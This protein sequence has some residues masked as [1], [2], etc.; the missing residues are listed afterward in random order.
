MR[1]VKCSKCVQNEGSKCEMAGNM[2]IEEYEDYFIDRVKN[3][4]YFAIHKQNDK[5][6]DKGE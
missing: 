5:Y 6:A 1:Q 4:P 2:T 3:C